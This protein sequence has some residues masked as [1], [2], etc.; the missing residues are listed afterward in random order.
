MYSVGEHSYTPLRNIKTAED[1]LILAGEY[2]YTPLGNIKTLF[3]ADGR[4]TMLGESI[5]D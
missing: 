3:S 1:T 4:L 2:S 5:A